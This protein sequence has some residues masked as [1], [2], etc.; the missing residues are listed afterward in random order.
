MYKLRLYIV[1]L[2]VGI[3]SVIFAVTLP[4]HSFYGANELYSVNQDE[5]LTDAGTRFLGINSRLLTENSSWG[6]EC[7]GES[8]G[9]VYKC[10]DCCG[11][12]LDKAE[13][14][15][16]SSEATDVLYD[17]CMEICEASSLPLGSALWLLPFAV[18]YT[19][20]RMRKVEE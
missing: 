15:D 20:I 2:L 16:G 7:M 18:V 1:F 12:R 8:N 9:D 11:I 19:C 6:N 14:K 13:E 17:T 10:Q 3:A 5:I 4:T